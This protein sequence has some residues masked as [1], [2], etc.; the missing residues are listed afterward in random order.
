MAQSPLDIEDPDEGGGY[1]VSVSDLMIG[2]LFVFLLMLMAFA[3][4]Y[5]HAERQQRQLIEQQQTRTKQLE[6]ELAA[7]RRRV[8]DAL[9][10]EI[11]RVHNA[12]T[13]AQML[14]DA[15]LSTLQDRL[16]RE[17]VVVQVVPESGILRLQEGILFGSMQADLSDQHDPAQPAKLS[18]REVVR[19]LAAA[20]ADVVPC[21]ANGA[22]MPS[23]CPADSGPILEAIFV[24]GHTDSRNV[25]PGGRITDNYQLSTERALSTY[26][27]LLVDRPSLKV[28]KNTAAE[29][30]FGLSGYGPD[31]P[32]HPGDRDE[33]MPPNRRIDVRFLLATPSLQ[34]LDT[35]RK[36]VNALTMPSSP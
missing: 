24:E 1:L 19:R 14:R 23:N 6:R 36:S 13:R 11:D 16:R 29:G 20:L 3:L 7:E 27:A 35:L 30:L 5:S 8:G 2:L 18:P 10:G 21:Y 4:Q 12:L 22:P 17:G 28:L 9:K 33:D 25:T 32:V 15:L 31:R 26:R 34:D